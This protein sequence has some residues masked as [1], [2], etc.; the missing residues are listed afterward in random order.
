MY[1]GKL[2]WGLMLIGINFIM[3]PR[4]TT[5]S[6]LFCL[7]FIDFITGVIKAKINGTART[8]EGFRR[9]LKK[10]PGYI[11]VPVVLWL[12]G[13]YAKTHVVSTESIDMIKMAKILQD[14]SGWIMLFIMYIEVT[15]I[16][17]NLSEIDKHGS[18]NKYFVKPLLIILKIGI[19]NNPMKRLSDKITVEKESKDTKTTVTVETEEK[20][21]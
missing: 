12:G 20:P 19:D 18:L 8:S 7:V 21:K 5:I 2:F 10:I 4:A 9:T 1:L 6:V 13:V 17:E 14:A 15:S 16:L 3:S 11:I